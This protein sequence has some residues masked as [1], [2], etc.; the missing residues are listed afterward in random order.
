MN[1]DRS[2]KILLAIPEYMYKE[3]EM[4]QPHINTTITGSI[5]TLIDHGLGYER[6]KLIN[7]A[8]QKQQLGM[9]DTQ[10]PKPVTADQENDNLKEKIAQEHGF[11]SF[12]EMETVLKTKSY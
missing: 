9:D 4:M 3:I 11:K 7:K 10:S 8:K 1:S 2:K 5:I 6:K 12:E